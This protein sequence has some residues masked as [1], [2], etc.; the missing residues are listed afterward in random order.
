MP[1]EIRRP[2]EDELRAAM[3]ATLTASA[4]SSED[5]DWERERKSVRLE[6]AVAAYDNGRPVG[7]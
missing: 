2:R 5:A 4:E 6:R 7:F 3:E 1:V